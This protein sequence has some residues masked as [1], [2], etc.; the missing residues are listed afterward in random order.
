MIYH[1]LNRGN[2]RMRLFHKDED[3][4]AFEKVLAQGLERYPR[5]PAHLLP[6]G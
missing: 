4:A 1:V 5:G 2:G 6:D 3:F